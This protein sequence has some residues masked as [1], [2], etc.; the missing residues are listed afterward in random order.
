MG[1]QAHKS[2][3]TV[4]LATALTTN[5][6]MAAYFQGESPH[7][8]FKVQSED[9]NEWSDRG[10]VAAIIGFGVFFIAYIITIGMIFF[11]ISWS[12]NSYDI[13]IA[14]DRETLIKMGLGDKMPEMER[15]LEI[16]LAGK[17]QEDALDNQL[18]EEARAL[19]RD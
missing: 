2:V 8:S 17:K 15:E 18:L 11:D 19:T 9:R 7:E 3:I 1:F 14:K 4:A 16:R 12:S 6:V 10:K 13:E 5:N